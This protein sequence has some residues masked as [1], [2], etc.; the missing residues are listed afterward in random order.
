LPVITSTSPSTSARKLDL[1]EKQQQR[2][3]QHSIRFERFNGAT[4]LAITGNYY[5]APS[6]EKLSSLDLA[7]LPGRRSPF[8]QGCGETRCGHHAG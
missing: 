4:V 3:D 1:N 5:G 6:A 7:R 8:L 2:V